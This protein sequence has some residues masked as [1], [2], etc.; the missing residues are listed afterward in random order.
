MSWSM[1]AMA[2]RKILMNTLPKA[3]SSFLLEH[4]DLQ[5]VAKPTVEYG[6]KQDESKEG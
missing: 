3:F 4:V 1:R 6:K 5:M 2:L